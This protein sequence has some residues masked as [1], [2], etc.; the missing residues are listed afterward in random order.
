MEY[1]TETM[2]RIFVNDTQCIKCTQMTLEMYIKNS[3]VVQTGSGRRK[4]RMVEVF[5]RMVPHFTD[6]RDCCE[7]ILYA[8]MEYAAAARLPAWPNALISFTINKVADTVGYI[9]YAHIMKSHA[10][11]K[12][13]LV[14]HSLLM[15]RT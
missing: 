2:C 4:V 10:C 12:R 5:M 13:S 9:L 14:K 1:N 11:T 8:V 7:L 15:Y 6:F 3:V